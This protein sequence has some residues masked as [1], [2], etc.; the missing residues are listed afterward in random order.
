[1]DANDPRLAKLPRWARQ[2][3]E[4]LEA[5]LQHFTERAAVAEGH[6]PQQ[7][8]PVVVDPYSGAPLRLLPDSTVRFEFG[9]HTYLDV[10]LIGLGSRSGPWVRLHS[11]DSLHIQPQATN[12]AHV[13]PEER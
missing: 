9:E 2:H 13:R 7:D 5:N 3:I 12:S 1:M 8:S 11:S 4:T 6:G 10:S